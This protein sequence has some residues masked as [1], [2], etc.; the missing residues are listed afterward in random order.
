M[1]SFQGNTH[2]LDALKLPGVRPEI[3]VPWMY[4][5]GMTLMLALGALALRQGPPWRVWLSA[6]VVVSLLGSLG[7]YTSPIWMARVVAVDFALAVHAGPA[8]Q[9]RPARYARR[10]RSGS[11]GFSAT[12]MAASTGG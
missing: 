2:W 7:Q 1:S 5:G 6:L 9:R 8:G 12:A 3:W 4:L 10:P 11:T